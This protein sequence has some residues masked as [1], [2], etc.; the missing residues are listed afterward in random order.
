MLGLWEDK[1]DIAGAVSKS[2]PDEATQALECLKARSTGVDVWCRRVGRLRKPFSAN[3]PVHLSRHRPCRARLLGGCCV[4]PKMQQSPLATSRECPCFRSG[5]L[6]MLNGPRSAASLAAFFSVQPET[7]L[8]V[9][10]RENLI[11]GL[12]NSGGIPRPWPK[13]PRFLENH[14]VAQASHSAE[15]TARISQPQAADR[16]L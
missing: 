14:D 10:A 7:S 2:V 4:F 13:K 6:E 11:E 12:S 16:S 15:L 3:R 9:A 5:L 1:H 8:V